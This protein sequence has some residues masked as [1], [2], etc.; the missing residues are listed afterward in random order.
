MEQFY[1]SCEEHSLKITPQR[2]AIYNRLKGAKDHPS[3]DTIYKKVRKNLP[4]ISFDTVYRT[5]LTFSKIGLIQ[6]VEG[7]GDSKRFDPNVDTHHHTRC[8]KCNTIGDFPHHS[9]DNFPVP[10]EISDGFT[11]RN[12]K[13]VVEGVCER[14]KTESE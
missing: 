6:V 14:C 3:A 9:H 8:V 4:N 1:R 12:V 2:I 13:V 11:I 10:A 5:L 7:Y